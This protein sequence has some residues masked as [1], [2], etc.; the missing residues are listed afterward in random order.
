MKQKFYSLLL[1]ALFGMLGMNVQ[2]LETTEIG[3]KTYFEITNADELAEF[4]NLV[5]GGEF[6]ANAVLTADI[7]MTDLCNMDGWTAIGDWGQISE[8]SN[9]CFKGHFDGQG[10]KITGFNATS[11]HN[12]YGIFGV[13]STGALIENFDIYGTM[14]LGHK[15]GGVVGYSRD[16]T[17][18][19][20][21]I[22][23]YMTINVTEAATSAERPGGIIGSAVNGTTVI[24]NC[25]YSGTLNVG[26]HTGNIGGIVGYVNNNAAAIVNITNCLFDGE[27][28]NGSADGQCGG[29]V[30]YNNGGTLTIKNCL[31]IGTIN[32]GDG[33]DGMF[34]GRLNGSN[35]TFANNYYVGDNVNGT[36]SGKSA[37]GTAPVK[38]TAA[39]LASGE[40]CFLLNES[41]SGGT[42][43]FQ[44]LKKKFFIAE[45]YVV[46]INGETQE[47]KIADVTLTSNGDGTYIFTLPDFVLYTFS[48]E[49][50]VGDISL[51]DVTINDDGTFHKEGN[52]DVPEKNI[53]SELAALASYF[54]NIPYIL[55][56][57]V[58]NDKL[59][60]TIDITHSMGSMGIYT[61]N[62]VAGTDDFIA[63]VPA[64]G[65]PYPAPYG[66]DIVYANGSF[67]C[68][69][70]PKEDSTV[71][72]SNSD[73]SIIDP[74]DF[75]EGFCSYCG[76]F[77]E[78]Y[79]TA[80]ADG[81]FEIGTANQLKWF[82]FYVNLVDPAV[83][84][85]LTADID[86][87][88]VEWTPIGKGVYFGGIFDGQNFTISNLNY[89]GS[90]DCNGLF[91]G[92]KD[93]TV[94]NFS[95]SGTIVCA[96]S[97]SGVIGRS[98]NATISNIHSALTIET[99]VP[100]A[101]HHAGGIVGGSYNPTTIDRCSFS[102]TMTVN[103]E[104]HDCFGGIVG[105]TTDKCLISNCINYGTIYF[106]KNNCYA[107][108]I[109]GYINS[110]A[111]Y[112]AHNCLNVG[113]VIYTG[114]GDPTYSG[115]IVGRLRGNNPELWGYNYYKEGSAVNANGENQIPTNYEVTDAQLTSGEVAAKMAP[116]I[117]QNID[118][119][120]YPV[121]DPT[122]NV[123]AEITAA[124]YATLYVP[125][126]DVTIPA[127]V[128]AFTGWKD[129][130]YLLMTSIEN[131]IAADEPVVL[132]GAA[133][134][135]SF[136]P[137]TGATKATTNELKGTAEDTDATGKY[138]LAQPE[139]EVIGL[140]L[141][142]GGILRAGKA[143]L[144]IPEGSDI[145]GFIFAFGNDATGIVSSLKDTEEGTIYNI[146][147][148]RVNKAQKGIYIVNGK[149]VLQ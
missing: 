66:T 65:D 64:E 58:N 19:I 49:L 47:P 87:T 3:G 38:V 134:I 88:D 51:E 22:H 32:T 126:T 105:Y 115:A 37:K 71:I 57:K 85:I 102:G 97:W 108:G 109:V 29:I 50:Y 74:H 72:Y 33:N 127:G 107:G 121:L 143:Y 103:S 73:N 18:T 100:G 25:A 42:N 56:G 90:G 77:D 68:D 149:K 52:F 63:A 13:I 23:S 113:D 92:I 41:V 12:Y 137:T 40:I 83:N 30:G 146:A 89:V 99:P 1:T 9:A 11:T 104:S 5:N 136:V 61:A 2:A 125:D 111:C 80:N 46:T 17:P 55:D 14:N 91:G 131:K 148:Q 138:V 27:I 10:H 96:G 82:A 94:M 31:S 118:E 142:D 44:T 81:Y 95:I 144:E 117:R 54:K 36:S 20:R 39:Q 133:G 84:A 147:G 130:T 43:W 114:E 70:T 120:T 110:N 28:E 139:G 78:T 62:V 45:Q 129:G 76:A 135:Y 93:A 79:M 48:R 26:G 106:A 119:D 98:E 60:A 69:M 101:F 16:A 35:T 53:P 116:Y 6:E 59:Y 75:V 86:M 8:T 4:S 34:I 132:K 112:G 141:A 145:K 21:N 122:H 140:Y 128:E 7:D 67:N 24:E 15:T 124:G 123:V